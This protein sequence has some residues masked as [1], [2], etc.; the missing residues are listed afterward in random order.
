MALVLG[1]AREG[2]QAE[3]G[4]PGRELVTLPPMPMPNFLA[5]RSQALLGCVVVLTAIAVCVSIVHGFALWAA[6]D[7]G[8][9]AD[10]WV[11]TVGLVYFE[12]ALALCCL[13]GLMLGDPGVIGR[14]EESCFPQPPE[15]AER[16]AQGQPLSAL[17][18]IAGDDGRTFC[19]RCLVWR[20]SPEDVGCRLPFLCCRAGSHHCAICQRCV[21]YFDHHCVVFGRCVAGRG[22][23]GNMP[24]FVGIILTAYAGAGTA[25]VSA[26]T[27][28]PHIL[29]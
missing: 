3:G 7:E 29:S 20:P 22:F 2:W 21:R 12:A 27:L 15:V 25:F 9:P 1:R 8:L 14:S 11:R 4:Q 23:G 19:V 6:G 18:N 26:F 17:R 16:L 10:L 24:Y 13:L 28:L 5:Q